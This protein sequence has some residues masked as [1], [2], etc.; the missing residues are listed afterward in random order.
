MNAISDKSLGVR[1][2]KESRTCGKFLFIYTNFL[3]WSSRNLGDFSFRW[4]NDVFIFLKKFRKKSQENNQA[5]EESLEKGKRSIDHYAKLSNHVVSIECDS[6]DESDSPNIWV[7]SDFLQIFRI[8]NGLIHGFY[9]FIYFNHNKI[10]FG[11]GW[12]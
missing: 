11:W 4:S 6:D 12:L 7:F 9:L 10:F 3:F 8:F 2:E 1:G 5:N